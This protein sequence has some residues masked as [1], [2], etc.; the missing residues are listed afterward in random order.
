MCRSVKPA[1]LTLQ[2]LQQEQTGVTHNLAMQTRAQS[3]WWHR[4]VTLC[5]AALATGSAAYWALKSVSSGPAV[6]A[7]GT[8]Q[9]TVATPNPQAIT[10]LLGGTPV[11]PAAGKLAVADTS[12]DRLKLTGVV[13]G[14]SDRGYALI[15][16]DGKPARP[17]GV[18]SQVTDTLVL[19]SV[20]VRSAAL[21]P[22]RTAPASVTLEL[23]KPP[24]P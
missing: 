16:V 7:S 15:S 23:P 1:K 13:A 18:G 17:F 21:G 3:V 6:P 10:R 2:V 14:R 8:A 19:R 11:A 9:M 4:F 12:G 20:A 22:D 24:Q 5:L